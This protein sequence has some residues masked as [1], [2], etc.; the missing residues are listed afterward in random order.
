MCARGGT[1][2]CA[3]FGGGHL[4]RRMETNHNKDA[5]I[6]KR[7]LAVFLTALK[8]TQN[9]LGVLA[10]VLSILTFIMPGSCA[11]MG[12]PPPITIDYKMRIYNIIGISVCILLIIVAY[13][14]S[15]VLMPKLIVPLM[16]KSV[17]VYGF[18]PE[19]KLH[20]A[21]A[22]HLLPDF[23]H[24]KGSQLIDGKRGDFFFKISNVTLFKEHGYGRT[25][26]SEEVFEG[27]C[28]ACIFDKPYVQANL[29]NLKKELCR[30]FD[31]KAIDV[32][33]Q[34]GVVFF[35]DT[36]PLFKSYTRKQI[37]ADIAKITDILDLA[38][39]VLFPDIQGK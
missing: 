39:A 35:L 13:H 29:D 16:E 17:V 30:R 3:G 6:S 36:M 20:I 37:A 15:N 25:S 23:T 22:D 21:E 4:G 5:K 34:S 14:I 8:V 26:Y 10:I 32:Y 38:E 31:L 1:G 28:V 11:R 19:E 33:E 27:I 18:K 7:L 24:Y 2:R 12:S 9:L